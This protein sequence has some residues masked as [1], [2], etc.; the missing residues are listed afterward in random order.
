MHFSINLEHKNIKS[1]ISTIKA[2]RITTVYNSKTI[3]FLQEM[4]SA[5]HLNLRFTSSCRSPL[6]GIPESFLI[7]SK[8][9]KS[10]YSQTQLIRSKFRILRNF[11]DTFQCRY[12]NFEL[13][14]L[15]MQKSQI[16]NFF[17]HNIDSEC[18][19]T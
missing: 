15:S 10:H 1:R 18:N 8:K 3:Q 6:E 13:Q 12:S 4:I 16:F 17:H 5:T 7:S 11:W 19:F 14:I 2:L 9:I